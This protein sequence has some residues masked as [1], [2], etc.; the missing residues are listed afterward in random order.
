MRST[1]KMEGNL[2]QENEQLAER[3]AKTVLRRE[4][5]MKMRQCYITEKL[6]ARPKQKKDEDKMH[7]LHLVISLALSTTAPWLAHCGDTNILLLLR[8]WRRHG[9]HIL[10]S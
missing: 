8:L 7:S 4:E 9:A 6:E 3:G 2:L 1:A 10:G 5:E